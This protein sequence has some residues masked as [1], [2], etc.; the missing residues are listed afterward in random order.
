VTVLS[1]IT[2][3]CERTLLT[4]PT[5]VMGTTDPQIKQIRAL[6]EEEGIDLAARGSWQG[7]TFEASHT[8]VATEDQGAISTIA[9]N[10]FNYIKNKTI[11][12]RTDRLPVL[13]PMDAAEWQAMK[14]V[15]TT[16][17]RYRF[18]IRGGKLLVNPTPAAGHSW[19]FEYV[20]KNW[21]LGADGTTYKQYFT[22]DTDTILLPETLVLM[23]LRW[24][25]KKEKGFDYAEDLR[26]Y[27]MQVKDAGGRD[28]GKPTVNMEGSSW[29]GPKP[30][31]WVPDGNWT[32]P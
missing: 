7:M 30:G 32:V 21:I 18:R 24:R 3:F 31:I 28:G 26:S 2:S 12:D 23:G 6:L 15:V 17:P 14:A 5:S 13:G 20:S 25:W 22:L 27:E 9:T 10:G 19:N 11:W 1:V 4:V 8:T 29:K 16:G